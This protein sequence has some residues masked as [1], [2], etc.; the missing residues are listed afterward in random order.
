[1]QNFSQLVVFVGLLLTFSKEGTPFIGELKYF[2]LRNILVQPPMETTRIPVMLYC[3]YEL[4]FAAVTAAIAIGAI[5]ERGR[6]GPVLVFVFIWT[7]LVYDPI[8]CWTWNKIGWSNHLGVLDFAGGIAVH[9][10]SGSSALAVS[11][12][13]GKRY[14]YDN[15][16]PYKPNNITNV[17]LGTV[18]M[19]FGWFG[20][21]GGSALSANLVA[22]SACINT[23]LAAA[24]GALTSVLLD[25]R[26]QKK[27]GAVSFCSGAVSGLIT[28]TPGSGFVGAPAALL[29]GILGGAI[30]N[31]ASNI[32]KLGNKDIL[33]DDSLAVR[34]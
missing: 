27:W 18:M 19:W 3:I 32:N 20:F 4:M 34:S 13:L 23:N 11:V 29:Y 6:P 14:E 12:Y 8:A 9:I 15:D 31:L 16:T 26:I 25:Y 10:S 17:V 33:Y 24:A 22:V 21:N 1:M 5:A 7:T 2:A 30:C 28:I